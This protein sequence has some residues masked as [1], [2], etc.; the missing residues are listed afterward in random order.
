MNRH[1]LVCWLVLNSLCLNAAVAQSPSRKDK[2]K[3][4]ELQ[5]GIEYAMPGPAKKFAEMGVPVV[6][7][8]PD[9]IPWGKMQKS[10]AAP[11]DFSKLDRLVREYQDA[12]FRD[13]VI[14]LKSLSDWASKDA[15]GLFPKGSSGNPGRSSSQGCE[16]KDCCFLPSSVCELPSVCAV[17]Y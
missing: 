11:I 15:K 13:C 1:G 9:E 16:I 10:A 14:V 8:Y 6:K 12:G 4:T 7:F 2:S 3:A 17:S 5:I